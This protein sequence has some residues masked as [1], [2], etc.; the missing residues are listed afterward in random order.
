MTSTEEAVFEKIAI[1]NPTK[2]L[3]VLPDCPAASKA[4]GVRA[5]A[6]RSFSSVLECVRIVLKW[7]DIATKD[8]RSTLQAILSAFSL[9]PSRNGN[10]GGDGKSKE[11]VQVQNQGTCESADS[12]ASFVVSEWGAKQF[13]QGCE[14]A[15]AYFL[16]FVPC[17]GG[18]GDD[19]GDDE[20]TQ[21]QST[22]A[23]MER[24]P[25]ILALL[26]SIYRVGEKLSLEMGAQDLRAL[27]SWRRRLGKQQKLISQ[28][29]RGF[30]R[31]SWSSALRSDGHEEE[32]E[33]GGE[34]EER[35]P[36]AVPPLVAGGWKGRTNDLAE[37]IRLCVT[38]A[39]DPLAEI[40]SFANDAFTR[41]VTI[42]TGKDNARPLDDL[43]SMSGL[44]LGTWYKTLWDIVQVRWKY[45]ST[46]AKSCRSVGVGVDD[47]TGGR[48][49]KK[50]V[51]A[52]LPTQHHNTTNEA[53]DSIIKESLAC[54]ATFN[55]LVSLISMHAR[56][57]VILNTAAKEGAIFL[58]G[59]LR[60]TL[61][62]W[63]DAFPTHT[64]PVI[65]C[66]KSIQKGTRKLNV[67]CTEG[68]IRRD[69]SVVARISRL[70]KAIESFVNESYLLMVDRAPWLLK[71]FGELK[72]KDLD[73]NLVTS[74]QLFPQAGVS[75]EG[76]EEEEEGEEE[77]EV[78]GEEGDE[79][80]AEG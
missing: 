1:R 60:S 62:F 75:E 51:P 80:E 40:Q 67:L 52:L 28:S 55:H 26:E 47:N 70:K 33:Y 11:D 14:H 3:H 63:R 64:D 22:T 21:T 34:G 44:T 65:E 49:M 78:E 29:A 8:R 46:A 74:S 4:T 38:Y 56:R 50:V 20:A 13:M 32:E 43:P 53:T 48:R 77:D 17:D 31:Q 45:V 61:S 66:I 30:L 58:E 39:A 79:D 76:E 5:S 57:T 54:C 73:G 27:A 72:H 2:L 7:N 37:A 18:G 6:Q 9:S 16:N 59:V 10:E 19:D 68:K 25:T 23:E 35:G 41:I 12:D 15:F 24:W 69:M 42:P 71:N 36:G